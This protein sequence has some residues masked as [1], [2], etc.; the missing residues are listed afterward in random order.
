MST[1]ADKPAAQHRVIV[2]ESRGGL[3]SE[4]PAQAIDFQEPYL[5]TLLGFIGLNDVT[6]IHAEKLGFGPTA[7]E[8][9]LAAAKQ[10]LA[11]A[12]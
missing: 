4:G 8:A 3:Y 9:A 7:R 12:S 1:G 5:R 6:F 10:A 2:I 11:E